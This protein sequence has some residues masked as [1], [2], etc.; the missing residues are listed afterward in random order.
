MASFDFSRFLV[1][2][3]RYPLGY[4]ALG[5]LLFAVL[6]FAGF[7]VPGGLSR[8]E[9]AS[10]ITSA[11]LDWSNLSSFAVPN[12][13]YHLIQ[14]ASLR[15]M[16]AS[17]FSVKLPSLILA[18]FAALGVI[19]L[20]QRWFKPNIAV[21]ASLI[22]ISTG[23]FLFIAQ[24][25]TPDILYV[26]WPVI[27]LLLGTQVTRQKNHRLL[28]KILFGVAVSLSLYTPYSAY[29]LLAVGL[30]VALHPHLRNV[31]RHLKPWRLAITLASALLIVAPL[32]LLII[33]QPSLLRELLGIPATMPD[34]AGNLKLLAEQYFF[35]WEPQTS[36]TMTPIFGLGAALLITLG[37]YRLIRTLDT[38]RSYL[39]C[40]WVLCLLPIVVLQPAVISLTFAPIVLLL[41]AGLTS[42][43][44]YWYRLF[45]HNPYA[46]IAGLIPIIVLVVSLIGSGLTRY[47][48]SYHYNPEAVA[49]FSNDLTL[50]PRDTGELLVGKDEQTFYKAIA[51]Y[52]GPL[53]VVSKPSAQHVTAT[54]QGKE[55]ASLDDYTLS[56]I[57]TNARSTDANRFYVYKSNP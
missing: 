4:S 34:I 39:V 50:L 25:G 3:W 44:S 10:V 53:V 13:P 2:R 19:F 29:I 23:Q 35:F 6:V 12:L 51:S 40:I 15:L 37:T 54:R 41:A 56:R 47:V 42:L 28:W 7:F 30:T 17:V 45:P 27:I 9:E 52:R 26:F 14:D 49:L 32:I 43:I 24:L 1:Y 20:L 5:L 22:A 8:A 36:T 57:V 11:Q 46:R 55:D 48:Y 38:T 16:D 33:E 21:L 31:I 18:L